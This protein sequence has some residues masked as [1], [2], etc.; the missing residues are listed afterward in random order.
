M[1]VELSDLA[2]E[3]FSDECEINKFIE[4]LLNRSITENQ[5]LPSRSNSH[6]QTDENH[7]KERAYIRTEYS[8]W[9][10]KRVRGETC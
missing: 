4:Y 10:Q 8:C 1:G 2:R 7:R 3:M 6:W 9:L 5:S